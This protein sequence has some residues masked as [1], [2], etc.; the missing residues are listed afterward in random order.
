M[1]RMVQECAGLGGDGVVAVQLT[2]TPFPAGGLEFQAI[3]TAV[4]ADGNVHPKQPFPSD[5]SGQDFAQADHCGL[6]AGGAGARHRGAIRHDD[7]RHPDPRR[8]LV[9]PGDAA[10]SP[11]WSRKRGTWHG[12][13]CAPTC[14]RH[15]G[16]GVV[17][18]ETTMLRSA[19]DP[20]ARPTATT[21]TTTSPRR[22]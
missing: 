22:P 10:A 20:A 1:S 8:V 14:G 4:R 5:L 15:G 21:S 17:V 11:S 2:I 6:G 18:Q 19:S 13:G 12:N 3:G 7:Y 9:E 16:A